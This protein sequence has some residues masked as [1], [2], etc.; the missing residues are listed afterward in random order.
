MVYHFFIDIQSQYF[1]LNIRSLL[2]QYPYNKNQKYIYQL[3]QMLIMLILLFNCVIGSCILS[4][5]TTV[6]ACRKRCREHK[7]C[8]CYWMDEKLSECHLHVS[9]NWTSCIYRNTY[10]INT[11]YARLSDRLTGDKSVI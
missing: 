9:F 2:I 11:V 5:L 1:Y 3:F 8:G 4:T 7:E 6:S 10:I